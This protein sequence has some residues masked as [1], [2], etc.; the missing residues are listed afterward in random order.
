MRLEL[1]FEVF[2]FFL[3]EPSVKKVF[4]FFDIDQPGRI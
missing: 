2:F 1:T 4:F 3:M